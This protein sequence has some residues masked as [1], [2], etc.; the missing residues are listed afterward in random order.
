MKPLLSS[1]GTAYAQ[2]PLAAAA[3]LFHKR[4]SLYAFHA[5]LPVWWIC[6]RPCFQRHSKRRSRCGVV[7]QRPTTLSQSRDRDTCRNIVVAAVHDRNGQPLLSSGVSR[8]NQE[9]DQMAA[10]RTTCMQASTSHETPVP[11]R[12]P[13]RARIYYGQCRAINNWRRRRTSAKFVCSKRL[14]SPNQNMLSPLQSKQ[15][16]GQSL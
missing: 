11:P 2:P 15:H 14:A 6:F 7:T 1:N 10:G 3:M 16:P 8:S 5:K 13:S 4:S 12:A 9:V